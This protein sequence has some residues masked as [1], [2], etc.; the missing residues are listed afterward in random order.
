[1]PITSSMSRTLRSEHGFTLIE[2]LV[3]ILIIG[4]LAAIA[5]P[6]FVGQRD[7]GYDADAKSNARNIYAQVESCAVANRGEYSNCTTAAQLGESTILMGNAEGQV[8]VTGATDDGYTIT[9]YSKTGKTFVM[10]KS[11]AGRTLTVGGTGSGTW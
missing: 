6:A 11:P 1:M 8:E 2:L 7:R 3:V 5:F 4:V 9:A 10:S